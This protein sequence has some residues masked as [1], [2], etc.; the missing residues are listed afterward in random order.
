MTLLPPVFVV[1]AMTAQV[2]PVP[3]TRGPSVILTACALGACFGAAV[4]EAARAA[5]KTTIVNN[6]ITQYPLR[7]VKYARRFDACPQIQVFTPLAA[8]KVP[9]LA[10]S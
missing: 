2:G 9:L 5:A 4:A 7:S 3:S 10:T 8:E 6:L 1:Q